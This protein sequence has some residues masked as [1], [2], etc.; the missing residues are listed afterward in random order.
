ME[1]FYDDLPIRDPKDDEFGYGAFAKAIAD[2]IRG[3]KRPNGSAIAI[4]GPWGAGKSSLVNLVLHELENS[5]DE[6][7]STDLIVISFS[8]WCYRGEEGIV[9]GFFRALKAGLPILGK[10]NKNYNLVKDLLTHLAISVG[11]AMAVDAGA[12]PAVI[13]VAESAARRHHDTQKG[14]KEE[15]KYM[16]KNKT[17]EELQEEIGEKLKERVLIVID[18]IDRLAP[19]EAMSVFR[20]IKSVG[21]IQNVMYL[22]SYDRKITENHISSKYSFEGSH[23][24]EKIVQANFDMPEPTPHV[25]EKIID[26]RLNEIIQEAIQNEINMDPQRVRNVIRDVV[27]PD[28]RN[29]RDIHR[30][31]NMLSVTY[32]AVRND[33]DM[34]DFV[35]IETLRFFHL[36]AYQAI[37][38]RKSILT[39]SRRFGDR[40]RL[41]ARIENEIICRMNKDVSQNKEKVRLKS[42]LAS[43]F[44]PINPYNAE[45]IDRDTYNWRI[46]KRVCSEIHFDTYFRFS[47]SSE[48][49]SESEFGEFVHNA[50]D[51]NF[52]R[53]KMLD[54]LSVE[55]SNQRSKAS[56]MLDNLAQRSEMIKDH[57][58]RD[59]LTAIYSISDELQEKFDEDVDFGHAV[60]NRT[61]IKWLSEKLFAMRFPV[62]QISREMLEICRNA[63]LNLQIEYC[64]VSLDHYY[65]NEGSVPRQQ[66]VPFTKDDTDEFRS[67]LSKRISGIYQCIGDDDY[68][69][70][71]F[72]YGNYVQ[73]ISDLHMILN[74][75]NKVESLFETMLDVSDENVLAVA[76][77]FDHSSP[78]DVFELI[79]SRLF[80]FKFNDLELKVTDEEGGD[81]LR[82]VIENFTKYKERWYEDE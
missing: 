81:V 31:F 66:W 25:L 22:L 28:V 82:R 56:I 3:I 29:I 15:K 51:Q 23:Y 65:W 37:R 80:M 40:E 4:H 41:D 46:E 68:E 57:Q 53:Q 70:V 43:L 77:E 14:Q 21:R 63:P 59:L 1:K 72:K 74:D 20:L 35:A 34:A 58:V 11:S 8:S 49:V 42:M 9:N 69:D 48:V 44:P 30:L 36:E 19:E 50:H 16:K 26:Q 79:T 78:S 45:Y 12:D 55:F 67:A 75:S 54:F 27:M 2:C 33:V 24:L 5:P 39:D 76:K 71:I 18:D 64:G 13:E 47:V 17:I 61:R 32:N 6:A 52:V 7:S 62:E 38:S 73:L 60:N 10:K